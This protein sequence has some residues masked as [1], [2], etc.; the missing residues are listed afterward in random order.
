MGRTCI[1]PMPDIS[2][3]QVSDTN[4]GTHSLHCLAYYI[5]KDYIKA[6]KDL[7]HNCRGLVTYQ[8]PPQTTDCV[9]PGV[10]AVTIVSNSI[11]E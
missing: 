7:F 6:T 2:L 5:Y 1:S 10:A 4:S 8:T 11:N 3:T 9:R